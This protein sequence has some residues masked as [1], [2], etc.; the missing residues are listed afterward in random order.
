MHLMLIQSQQSS[1]VG[2]AQQT[3][4]S[5]ADSHSGSL[6]TPWVRL[7]RALWHTAITRLVA[8]T[9]APRPQR[10][11][12]GDRP[13]VAP[14]AL[15]PRV[16]AVTEGD[17]LQPEASS[18]RP[19]GGARGYRSSVSQHDGLEPVQH[20]CPLLSFHSG[21]VVRTTSNTVGC[22]VQR[23]QIGCVYCVLHK[24]SSDEAFC[25]RRITI[26]KL[27]KKNV[28]EVSM[29]F[30]TELM[31]KIEDGKWFDEQS[32]DPFWILAWILDVCIKAR[33]ILP[34]PI[35]SSSDPL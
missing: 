16:N 12:L 33:I 25:F 7:G 28:L 18:W 23:T 3:K 8:E 31:C 20:C 10:R 14:A 35:L 6:Q 30:K 2:A 34:C 21:I 4:T 32:N 29:F 22:C 26:A 5:L 9:P 11:R 15:C 13:L 1:T 17:C 19:H 27:T 24:L